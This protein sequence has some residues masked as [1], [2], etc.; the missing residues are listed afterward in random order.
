MELRKRIEALQKFQK[1]FNSNC[2]YEFTKL[3]QGDIDLRINMF[4]EEAEE[5]LKAYRLRDKVEILDAIADM[6]FLTVGD[7]V[8][9]G[10]QDKLSASTPKWMYF[11]SP[12]VLAIHCLSWVDDLVANEE[13]RVLSSCTDRLQAIMAIAH[14][15]YQDDAKEIVNEAMEAVESS[16]M[17]KLGEDGKPILNAPDSPYYDANKPINKIL[18]N[19]A[20]YFEPTEK[21]TNILNYYGHI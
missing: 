9:F 1:A 15:L 17:S 8:S 12:K 16:N 10:V 2:N 20:T 7:A 5:F 4:D 11:N 19:P 14:Y 21:L 6:I 18:K 13:S 3:T